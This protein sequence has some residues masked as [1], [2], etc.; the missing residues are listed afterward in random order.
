MKNALKKTGTHAAGVSINMKTRILALALVVVLLF[1]LAACDFTSGTVIQITTGL[2]GKGTIEQNKEVDSIFG[3]EYAEERFELNFHWFNI[4]HELGHGIIAFNGGSRL[5]SVDQEQLVN[6]FAVAFWTYYGEEEKL[7]ELE[8][9][10][11]YALENV[12]RPVDENTTHI[13]YARE[14]W[15]T[16]GG[17][18]E[19]FTFNNYGWF[20]FSCV[21]DSLRERRSLES[22]LTQMGVKD[23]AVQPQKTLVYPTVGKDTV[24]QIIGDAV[25]LLHEWGAELPDVYVTFSDEPHMHE[26]RTISPATAK[27]NVET[28]KSVV[29]FQSDDG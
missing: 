25:S 24:P 15:K 19:L 6:D 5:D 18:E 26:F 21:S 23:I 13:E 14:K 16:P 1:G 17:F 10:T 2:Y 27:R 20:Q 11:A 4:V 7:K 3:E 28:G 12:K 29:A 8:A 22:V 9:L